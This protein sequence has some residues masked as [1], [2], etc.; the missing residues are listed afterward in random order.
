MHALILLMLLVVFPFPRMGFTSQP[1]VLPRDASYILVGGQN[2]TWYRPDQEPRLYRISLPS[3][4]VAELTP[5]E[6]QGTVWTGG[7]NGSQWLI[8]GWG[9]NPEPAGSNPYIFM[10]DGRNQIVA[11]SLNQ[12]ASESSWRGGDVFAVSYDGKHW[13]LAGLGSDTLITP[14]YNPNKLQN[15]M[16]LATFDG[17][18]FTDLS[19]IAPRQQDAILYANAWNGTHWLIGGGYGK[20][21]VLFTFNESEIIDLT[22]NLHEVVR[23]FASI[24]SIAWNGNYWLIGGIGFLAK[25]DGYNFVDLT[26]ELNAAL[27]KAYVSHLTVNAMAWN[28]SAWMIGGGSPV[29][30]LTTES[31]WAALYGTHG[32]VDLSPSLREAYGSKSYDPYSSILSICDSGDS[33]YLGGYSRNHGLLLT[34]VNGGFVNLSNLVN[35]T[36]SYVTWVGAPTTPP[37]SV[38][39]FHIIL[40]I[41]MLSIA[42]GLVILHKRCYARGAVRKASTG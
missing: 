28:G 16:A 13:L 20:A 37:S 14:T 30:Q 31:A 38:P 29:A 42:L 23:S 27:S 11:R 18:E 39:E 15:H 3:Y 36:M 40:P 19:G 24:Q 9:A 32:F 21:G 35:T 6:G 12:Y 5:V 25:Y 7:W 41:L 1:S 4:A 8:S 10:Y 17:Y 26:S 33:W 22:D 2:G 34:Y